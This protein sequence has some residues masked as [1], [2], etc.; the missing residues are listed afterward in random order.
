MDSTLIWG[1]GGQR[2]AL[3]DKDVLLCLS[4]PHFLKENRGGVVMS[5]FIVF[6]HLS[7]RHW[8]DSDT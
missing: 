4:R 1:L 6:P 7:K 3:K 2:M 8:W 5:D